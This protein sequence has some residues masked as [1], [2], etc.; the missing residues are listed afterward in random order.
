MVDLNML[1]VGDHIR[2]KSSGRIGT[3][4]GISSKGKARIKS[5]N[6]IFLVSASNLESYE[7]K[8]EESVI[9]F[10]DLVKDKSHKVNK[11]S[12]ENS[13]DLHIEK[14]NPSLI[15]GLPERIIDFQTKAFLSFF[16]NAKSL[17]VPVITIIH[18]KGTG[19]LKQV[20]QSIVKGDDAVLSFK[21]INNGGATEVALFP[22]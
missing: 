20:V 12:F 17:N 8:E 19:A 1:W 11:A 13:I 16:D 4:E 2:V 3:F 6:K 18:G 7:V 22:Y 10:S 5:E 14:L 21:E 15:N 9:E